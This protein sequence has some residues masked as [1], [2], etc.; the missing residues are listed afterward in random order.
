MMDALEIVNLLARWMHILAAITAVGGTFFA[1]FVVVPA[2]E[3]LPAEQR[4]QL[5]AALRARWS[6]IVA[7]AIGFLLVSG[8]YN[9][10]MISIRYQLPG[11]YQPVF[12]LK[13]VLA[14]AIFM[15]ASLLSGRTPAA[16][17]LRRHLRTWLNVNIALAVAV[18]CLS[19]I[20]RTADKIPKE[21]PPAAAVSRPLTLDCVARRPGRFALAVRSINL[22]I[23]GASEQTRTSRR[24]AAN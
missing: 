19:G 3:P 2:L 10:G 5:H 8:L 24:H 22:E 16:D 17:R 1:R 12:F 23:D 13:F 20:L 4:A 14:L 6:K 11:W 18:V 15:I 21:R 7:L 9:I